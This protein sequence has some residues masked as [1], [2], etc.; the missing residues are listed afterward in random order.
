MLLAALSWSLMSLCVKILSISH[1]PMPTFQIIWARSLV[2]GIIAGIQIKLKNLELK[3]PVECRI[4]LLL[5]G[6]TGFC[7][8]SFGFMAL[9]VL[10]VGDAV[11]LSFTAPIFTG[12]PTA[13]YHYVL[14]IAGH[15]LLNEPWQFIILII[16]LFATQQGR[17]RI[18][19]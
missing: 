18:I 9:T 5:R 3:G 12:I 2:T 16:D 17:G 19:A 8:M 7:G 13:I 6:L 11:A 4:L 10:S 14:G 1:E 15:F